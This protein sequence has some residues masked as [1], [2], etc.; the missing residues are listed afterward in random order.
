M[1]RMLVVV[2]G[3]T[4]AIGLN[5]SGPASQPTVAQIK[6]DIVGHSDNFVL[7]NSY[8]SNGNDP[9]HG[10]IDLETGAGRWLSSNG[11]VLTF[12]TVTPKPHDPTQVIVS[13]TTIDYSTRTWNRTSR[14]EPTKTAR[15]VVVDPLT[16][17]PEGVRFS[18]IGVEQVDG[19]QAYHL[20]STY[21]P[22][23]PNT[24]IHAW[25]S[26]DQAYLV[27][28]T[29]T[30]KDGTVVQRIDNRWLPRTRAEL[31]LLKATIPKGFK[32]VFVS[33]S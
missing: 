31:A 13:D 9:G 23:Q 11:K 24:R 8:G 2:A 17:S 16:S 12:R 28:L 25:F 7:A 26:T 20:R 27:R 30:T 10:W 1:L 29:R 6:A 19:R 33:P 5:V 3:A 15:P 32:Q 22:S 21:T 4:A 18:L 14:Q